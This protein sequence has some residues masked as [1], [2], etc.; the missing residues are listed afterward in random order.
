MKV[1]LVIVNYHSSR[2]LKACL[3]SVRWGRLSH[4]VMVVDNDRHNVGY[5]AG[6]NSGAKTARGEYL[7]VSNPDVI[8]QGD[9]VIKLVNYLDKHPKI[10]AVGPNLPATNHLGILEGLVVLGV[11]NKWFPKNPI[12]KKYW[13][14]D[15][16][17]DDKVKHSECLNGCCFLIRRKVFEKL[18]GFDPKFF[19]YFEENDL[20]ARLQKLGGKVAILPQAHVTHIG[21]VSSGGRG[22]KAEFVKS[23]KY[24]FQ[25]HYGAFWSWVIESFVG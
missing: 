17:G 6:I 21:Q 1:S 19:L 12:S 7:L 16:V 20:F 9:A 4:E 10:S 14:P 15:L 13:I 3:A 25:K 2:A 24:Y 5:G 18:G 23:R 11:L 22:N 8:Y